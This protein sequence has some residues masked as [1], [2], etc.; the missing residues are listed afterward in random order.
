[1]YIYTYIYI[2]IETGL[3]AVTATTIQT[4]IY[5]TKNFPKSQDPPGQQCDTFYLCLMQF[6][7]NARNLAGQEVRTILYK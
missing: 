6:F 3:M 1:M 7:P 4:T 2:Y 5:C